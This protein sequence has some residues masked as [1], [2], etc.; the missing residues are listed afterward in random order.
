M[1]RLTKGCTAACAVFAA[2]GYTGPAWAQPGDAEAAPAIEISGNIGLVSDYRYRG[3]SLSDRDPAIQGGIDITHES[4]LFVGTWASSIADYGG[5]NVELDLYGG[6]GGQAAG[7][8]YSV[9]ALAYVYPGGHGVDY[10]EL[11]G[12]AAKTFGPATVDLELSWV[13]DQ[14]H[15]RGDNVYVRAGAELAIPDTPLTLSAH[16][17]RE[18]SD[19]IKK[20]DWEASAAYSF[21]K[22]T[23]KLSYVDSDYGGA[24]EAGRLGRATLVASLVA[25]F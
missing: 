8:D 22:L 10:F 24:D 5:S 20:W 21:D 15:Y 13:P 16:A 4:G 18:S 2:N 12:T 17:G 14:K 25:A 3:L 11:K 9:S 19:F 1:N 23:A 6:Y 7:I